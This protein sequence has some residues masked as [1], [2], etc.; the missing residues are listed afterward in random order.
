MINCYIIATIHCKMSFSDFVLIHVMMTRI[1]DHH[2]LPI[3]IDD[4]TQSGSPYD[5]PQNH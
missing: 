4:I 3:I 5:R 1:F 2:V